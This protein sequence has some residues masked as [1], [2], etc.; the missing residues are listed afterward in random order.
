MASQSGGDGGGKWGGWIRWRGSGLGGE[1]ADKAWRGFSLHRRAGVVLHLQTCAGRR[2]L[3]QCVLGVA[4]IL[5][6]SDSEV[7][8]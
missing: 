5:V 8:F 7:Y 1:W 4:W 6:R 3:A 2:K